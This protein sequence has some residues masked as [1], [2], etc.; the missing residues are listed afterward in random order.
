[1]TEN[2]KASVL[3][4]A[5]IAVIAT[6]CALY[7][8]SQ[9]LR[10]SVGVIA[11]NL[12]DELHLTAAEIGFLSSAYFLIFGVSQV[13]L[14]IALD[15]FGPKSCLLVSAA[16]VVA[17]CVAFALA[18]AVNGL[19]A[20]RML[21][22]LGTASFLM[23]PLALYA[24]WF[25]PA[26]FSTLAGIQ[27]GVG[28]LGSLFATAPLAFAAA[29]I[30]WR[31]TFLIIAT[32][33]VGLGTLVFLIVRDDPPG[34]RSMRRRES[35]RESVAGVGAVIRTP[36][37]G[38]IFL[39]L[40]ASYPSFLLIVGLWGG[41]YLTHIYGYDLK[42]RGELLF[43]PALAQV[44]GSLLWGPMDRL[45]GR[46]KLP[47]LIGLSLNT[48]V[49]LLLALLGKPSL[50]LLLVLL[51]ALGFS[52]G[53]T[54]LLMAQARLLLPP[55]LLGRG[56]TLLNVGPM[57]GG[58]LAQFVSGAVITLFETQNGAYPLA[59]YQLVFALQAA[60]A[61]VAGLVY[62]RS[63]LRISAQLSAQ[64][65]RA[66]WRVRNI[67]LNKDYSYAKNDGHILRK[68]M[69]VALAFCALRLHIAAARQCDPS[70]FRRPLWA[71][72]P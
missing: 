58:F 6:L 63:Y 40:L 24:R 57:G 56:I 42:G 45:F 36:S 53:L 47:V 67:V 28:S 70:H 51:I 64:P 1:M 39:V 8:V 22:G 2:G 9:F 13:P 31:M 52:T 19:V 30:G 61:L 33:T 26:R 32:I 15:R 7:M 29:A 14:G 12:A 60:F 5:A 54:P 21:L 25:A 11:P 49:L 59:A 20:A 44:F 50:P 37:I 71:F 34:A 48:V 62:L 23:A 65:R 17:G 38:R 41:P 18:Q 46:Y 55:H 72:P 4:A 69:S 3:S 10:N 68:L 66:A 43:I 27:I 35:L 16:L